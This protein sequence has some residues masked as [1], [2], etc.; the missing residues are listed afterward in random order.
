MNLDR[1]IRQTIR[2]ILNESKYGML[3]E[4]AY[5][6]NVYKEKI[7]N[8]F[9][10][11][12]ENWCLIRYCTITKRE[13]TK[14]H[15]IDELRGFLSSASRFSIK[16]N[17]SANSR[18]KVLNEIIND[19]DYSLPQFVNLTV[20]NKFIIEKIDTSSKEYYQTIND[21]CNNLQNIANIILSRSLQEIN[22]YAFSI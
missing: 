19:N 2:R 5:K 9:P 4:M 12:L 21:C 7:D 1:E 16:G 14:N 6:R 13:K 17:D 11:I 22:R 10:Q 20:G 18:L 15:W 3:N 8:I